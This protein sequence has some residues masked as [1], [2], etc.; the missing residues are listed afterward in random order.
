[1]ADDDGSAKSKTVEN[2]PQA[3]SARASLCGSREGGVSGDDLEA[4]IKAHPERALE[5]AK[6][7]T[8]IHRDRAVEKLPD[9]QVAAPKPAGRVKAVAFV[10]KQRKTNL[11]EALEADEG[12]HA[13]EDEEDDGEMSQ[14]KEKKESKQK[15]PRVFRSAG[16]QN[17]FMIQFPATMGCGGMRLGTAASVSAVVINGPFQKEDKLLEAGQSSSR[18]DHKERCAECA[19]CGSPDEIR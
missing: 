3:T 1:V 9:L 17:E 13:D 5:M 19:V 2:T 12:E 14:P 7:A 6:A 8:D 4:F 10:K 11:V 18:A 16:E 15:S